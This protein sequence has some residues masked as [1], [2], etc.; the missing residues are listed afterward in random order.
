LLRERSSGTLGPVTAYRPS[1]HPR[2]EPSMPG[3]STAQLG[4]YIGLASLSVLF[5]AS[6]IGYFVTRYQNDS[7]RTADLPNLPSGLWASSVVL[8]FLSIALRYGERRLLQNDR[9]GLR[10]GVTMALGAGAL[11]LVLQAAN[12]RSV[13][14]ASLGTSAQTL[15][16]FTFYMLTAL[17]ALH[18]LGGIVPLSVI[19][20]RAADYSSSRHEMVRLTRQYWDFLLIV[21]VVLFASL[22]L[23]S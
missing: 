13:A 9:D 4:M 14:A 19:Y 2:R 5:L 7:W 21:W 8:V 23:S 10:R 18:V 11:F 1:E 22:G 6:L 20:A 3:T 17:H 16:A 15:Y 12:W